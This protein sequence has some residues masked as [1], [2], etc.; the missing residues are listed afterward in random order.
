V[1][2]D[3]RRRSRPADPA[4]VLARFRDH[5]PNKIAGFL[6]GSPPSAHGWLD[7]GRDSGL[8]DIARDAAS[9]AASPVSGLFGPVA[10]PACVTV[11][12]LSIRIAWW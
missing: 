8:S 11:F 9:T 3:R 1:P 10:T 7:G 6:A 2:R 4:R 5:R 12:S